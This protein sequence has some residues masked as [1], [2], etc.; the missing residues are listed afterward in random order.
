[1]P[2]IAWLQQAKN[3]PGMNSKS[4]VAEDGPRH[5]VAVTERDVLGF[6]FYYGADH[7]I[8]LLFLYL[9]NN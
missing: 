3:I 4:N 9:S 2:K 1:M 6:F 8:M 7:S 5:I